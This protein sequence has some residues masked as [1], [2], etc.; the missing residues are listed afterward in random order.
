MG[1]ALKTTQ[2]RSPPKV[3]DDILR[4]PL[5]SPSR[6]MTYMLAVYSKPT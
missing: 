5:G 6:H 4:S 2:L 3:P 1:K